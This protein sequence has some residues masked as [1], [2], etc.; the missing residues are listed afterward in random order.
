MGAQ[1]NTDAA[2]AGSADKSAGHE[3]ADVLEEGQDVSWTWGGGTATG[4]VA[5]VVE[6]GSARVTSDKGNTA[7]RHAREGDPAVEITRD[8]NDVVKLAHELNEVEDAAEMPSRRVC[9]LAR[10]ICYEIDG[11]KLTAMKRYTEVCTISIPGLPSSSCIN[12]LCEANRQ[13]QGP[14]LKLKDE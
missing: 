4:K 13:R 9:K 5:A 2:E 1:S 11:T 3:V 8:G 7:I 12:R 10:V 14:V 6:E